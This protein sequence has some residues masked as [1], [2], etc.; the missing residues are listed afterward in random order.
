MPM[1]PAGGLFIIESSSGHVTLT[2]SDTLTVDVPIN[3]PKE[4][5]VDVSDGFR[6]SYTNASGY[7]VH[8]RGEDAASLLAGPGR[9]LPHRAQRRRSPVAQVSPLHRRRV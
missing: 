8:F 9:A 5:D 6:G 7:R 3:L 4:T 1:K 2:A